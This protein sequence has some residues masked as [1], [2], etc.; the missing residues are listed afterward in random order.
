MAANLRGSASTG[1]EA[2][3]RNRTAAVRAAA[4]VPVPALLAVSTAVAAAVLWLAPVPP[5]GWLALR[6][7]LQF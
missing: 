3:M 4:T 5:W 7:F 2:E 1:F 6:V